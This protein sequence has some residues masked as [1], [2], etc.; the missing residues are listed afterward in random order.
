MFSLVG[1]GLMLAAA[2]FFSTYGILIKVMDSAFSV[3]DIAF[4][5]FLGSLVIFAPAGFLKYQ[6]FKTPTPKLM[7]LRG[8]TGSVAF[9]S[10]VLSIRLI[11]VSTALVLFYSFPAFA[12]LFEVVFL[13]V[14]ISFIE[15]ICIILAF[16]GIFIMLDFQMESLFLGQ[17]MGIN[18]GLFAGLSVCIIKILRPNNGS[19]PIYLYFCLVGGI[20]TAPVFFF[21]PHWPANGLDTILILVMIFSA[22]LGQIAMN[23]GFKYCKSWEGGLFLTT[24]LIFVSVFGLFFLGETATWRFF[25]GGALIFASVVTVHMLRKDKRLPDVVTKVPQ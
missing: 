2:I 5:R 20:L 1:P 18:A 11:P 22:S 13:K 14:K 7:I 15:I 17:I 16:T 12:A 19:I 6:P 3:W 8:I 25:T 10:L 24:E 4:Y 21:R 23:E 9:I